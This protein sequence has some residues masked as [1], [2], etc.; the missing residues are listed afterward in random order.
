[1][2]HGLIVDFRK[3]LEPVCIFQ[4]I[5]TILLANQERM[6]LL[7]PSCFGITHTTEE[8]TSYLFMLVDSI[9]NHGA[10][11]EDDIFLFVVQNE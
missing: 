4:K 1:M 6:L 3:G 10:I 9:L 11:F 7:L 2:V 5:W 8:A